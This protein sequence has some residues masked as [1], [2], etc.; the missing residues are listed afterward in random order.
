MDACMQFAMILANCMQAVSACPGEMGPFKDHLT[1]HSKSNLGNFLHQ[2]LPE[3]LVNVYSYHVIMKVCLAVVCVE[4][5][6]CRI[7][8]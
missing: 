3:L 1:S 6:F 8:S 5:D 7:R 2:Y 4:T